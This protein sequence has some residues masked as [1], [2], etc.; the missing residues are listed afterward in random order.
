MRVSLR[1]SLYHRL[2]INRGPDPIVVRSED[3]T[4]KGRLTKKILQTG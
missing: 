2:L 4:M 3:K 1:E